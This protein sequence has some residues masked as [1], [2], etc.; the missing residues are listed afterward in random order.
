MYQVVTIL[1]LSRPPNS[2]NPYKHWFVTTSRPNQPFSR[3][4]RGEEGSVRWLVRLSV[5]VRF[6]SVPVRFEKRTKPLLPLV[7]HGWYGSTV[8]FSGVPGGRKNGQ[9]PSPTVIN[10]SLCG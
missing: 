4:C 9:Q 8:A 10:R 7:W 3:V 2:R 6:P 5:P 1:H